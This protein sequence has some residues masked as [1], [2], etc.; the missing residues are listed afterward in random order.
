[1]ESGIITT[2]LDGEGDFISHVRCDIAVGGTRSGTLE[3]AEFAEVSILTERD[4]RID[5][6]I[7]DLAGDGKAIRFDEVEGFARSRELEIGVQVT[8]IDWSP[9]FG[10]SKDDQE[11]I[12][13]HGDRGEGPFGQVVRIIAQMPAIEV[14]CSC[15]FVENFNPIAG[16]TIFIEKGAAI[17]GH[18]LVNSEGRFGDGER[19]AFF[20]GEARAVNGAD[21]E[22]K[23][24]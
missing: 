9:V 23:G 1:M 16:R 20:K 7:C 5:L 8:T 10:G 4:V 19:K 22:G 18:Q 17:A 24:G 14:C 15:L 11:F 21:P 13:S 6:G 3:E 2:A 12:G